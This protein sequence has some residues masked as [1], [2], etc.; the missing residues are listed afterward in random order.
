MNLEKLKDTARKLE[1]KEDWRKAIE[2]YLKAIQQAESGA[3]TTPDLSLY[4]RV[5]DLYLKINDTAEAVRSYERAVDL[6]ADQGFFNNAIA[7]CG[8]ILRVNPGRTQTYLKLSQLHARKNVV[9]EAKRNLIEFLERMNALGQLDQA[10]QAVKLFAD[11]F[12]GSQEIRSMLVELLRATSREDE[13]REQLEKMAEDLEAMGDKAGARKARERLSSTAPEAPE[14]SPPGAPAS[15]PPSPPRRGDLIFLDTGVDL[16]A[17]SAP[18]AAHARPKEPH[19]PV[20][21]PRPVKEP[22]PSIPDT[23]VPEGLISN[24]SLTPPSDGIDDLIID[25]LITETPLESDTIAGLERIGDPLLEGNLDLDSP[26]EIQHQEPPDLGY[27]G[28]QLDGMQGTGNEFAPDLGAGSLDL[29]DDFGV[30]ETDLVL[31]MPAEPETTLES[32]LDSEPALDSE[33]LLDSEP[34]DVTG[35]LPLIQAEDVGEPTLADLEER[36]LDDPENPDVHLAMAEGLLAAGEDSRVSEELELALAGYEDREDWARAAEM[37]DRLVELTP[38]SVSYHQKRVELAYRAGDRGP[39]LEAYLGLGDALAKSGALDKA[40]AV[41][42]RVIEHDPNHARAAAALE[43][44]GVPAEVKREAPPP[45]TPAAKPKPAPKPQ[46]PPPAPP[47]PVPAPPPPAPA[48]PKPAA[49]TSSPPPAPPKPAPAA[50]TPKRAAAEAPGDFVDLGSMVFEEEKQRDTRMRVNRRE[51]QDQD[52]QREFHEIL[53]QFKRGIE[54]NLD[55][56]DY[57]AHY[58][59]GV[60]FKE[61][62]LLDEAIGEF[63]KALRAPEGR[64]RTSEALGMAFFEKGQY[65]VCESVLKRAVDSLSGSDE[66][67]IGLLY[68]MGRASEAL[69]KPADAVATYERAMVVDIGF[70]D[71]SKRVQKL[72]AGRRQ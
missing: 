7:L 5:G 33:S 71:L 10:F 28:I 22:P 55:S 8:K 25:S 26:L 36:V 46:S 50:P 54:Q 64:L 41:Y 17:P 68:W 48:A 47:K 51:P 65:A 44:L 19:R 32:M 60:A 39:L 27:E 9:I 70:M 15:A 49:A 20:E 3:E 40:I 37:A 62:G 69:G 16:G 43:R 18:P 35:G 58:D 57:E 11:Q 12:S 42:G 1:Q 14:H 23:T 31:D 67:K 13:A 2:V 24:E 59:L 66:A 61:M 30:G 21:P 72:S 6:Y 29:P 4:N 45:P 63:Q 38:D 34:P 53:E 52:E 56:E